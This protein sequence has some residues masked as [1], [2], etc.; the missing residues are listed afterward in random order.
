MA[1]NGRFST[2]EALEKERRIL[3]FDEATIFVWLV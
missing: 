1:R 2:P 3:S